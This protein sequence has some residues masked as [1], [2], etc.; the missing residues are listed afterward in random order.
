MP[1]ARGQG[2]WKEGRRGAWKEGRGPP[3]LTEGKRGQSYGEPEL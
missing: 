2:R 3:P 1:V